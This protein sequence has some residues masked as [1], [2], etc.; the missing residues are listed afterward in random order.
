[1]RRSIGINGKFAVVGKCRV[2]GRAKSGQF[3]LQ[4]DDKIGP[5]SGKAHRIAVSGK[6]FLA[7]C[8]GKELC[9]VV[10]VGAGTNDMEITA[11]Q[12]LCRMDENGHL[13]RAAIKY[14]APTVSGR[15][16]IPPLFGHEVYIAIERQ[17]IP[18]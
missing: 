16:K 14:T 9:A 3:G 18:T 15:H 2:H 1:M 4:L 6:P 7:V 12:C 8:P 10:G 11:F 17:V 13:E 5:R